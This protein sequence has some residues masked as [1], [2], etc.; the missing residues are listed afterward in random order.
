MKNF[1]ILLTLVGNYTVL[2]FIAY[3]YYSRAKI[4]ANINDL[5]N[6]RVLL[7]LGLVDRNSAQITQQCMDSFCNLVQMEGVSYD[8][9]IDCL[10]DI[11][12]W[13]SEPHAYEKKICLCYAKDLWLEKWKAGDKI[14]PD[15]MPIK[16]AKTTAKPSSNV[17]KDD[18]EELPDADDDDVTIFMAPILAC[19]A[20]NCTCE[21]H[22]CTCPE[23]PD[24]LTHI[25]NG[26][27]TSE[28]ICSILF[29][30]LF[31]LYS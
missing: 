18:L 26:I 10:K 6:F 4:Y 31:Y 9:E 5:I 30:K 2:S 8:K 23:C 3:C 14:C 21:G 22:N 28:V 29:L 7:G 1:V 19:R 13:P 24:F 25:L 20:S 12:V 16:R 27:F 11:S 17:E 15:T